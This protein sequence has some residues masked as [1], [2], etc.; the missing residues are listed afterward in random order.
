M[1]SWPAPGV[2]PPPASRSPGRPVLRAGHEKPWVSTHL[3]KRLLR[4]VD[5]YLTGP[6]GLSTTYCSWHLP[7][8]LAR[9]GW[10]MSPPLPQRGQ[11]GW[12]APH[13]RRW[14]STLNP[15]HTH[16]C[17]T[18]TSKAEHLTAPEAGACFRADL[19]S[20]RQGGAATVQ[21]LRG[22]LKKSKKETPYDLVISYGVFT[23]RKPLT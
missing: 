4:Q 19:N 18:R 16:P 17:E 9:P 21:T 12:S 13:G 10:H 3:P 6:R 5:P 14:P 11:G 22:F 15:L 8:S 7:P 20:S 23:Q 2:R 1:D